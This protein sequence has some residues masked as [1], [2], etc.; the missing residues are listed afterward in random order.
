MAA[1]WIF[2]F[3]ESDEIHVEE[4]AKIHKVPVEVVRKHYKIMLE[5]I[6]DELQ[7]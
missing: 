4:I 3:G 1:Y 6:K 7:G 2:L 5:A